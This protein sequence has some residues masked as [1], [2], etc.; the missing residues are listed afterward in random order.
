VSSNSVEVIYE[1]KFQCII[2]SKHTVFIENINLINIFLKF[3]VQSIE[4]K[5]DSLGILTDHPNLVL[6]I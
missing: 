5:A 2:E 1:K 6:G 4:F 3:V